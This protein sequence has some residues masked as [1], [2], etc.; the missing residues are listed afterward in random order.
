M[1][2]GAVVSDSLPKGIIRI[3][4]GAWYGPVGDDGSVED[5][6][7][8]GAL[9]SYG[10]PNNL[11]LDIGTSKLAQACSAYICLVEFEKYR[12]KVPLVSS[13]NGPIE[14]QI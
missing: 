11:T 9:Y 4:E 12:G 3:Q 2:A 8:I 13:F 6:A 10:D 1:L 7:K 14:T 5:G